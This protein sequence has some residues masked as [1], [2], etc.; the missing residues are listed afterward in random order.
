MN[1]SKPVF[2]IRP[3]KPV[4]PVEPIV[5]PPAPTAPTTDLQDMQAIAVAAFTAAKMPSQYTTFDLPNWLACLVAK[6][7]GGKPVL[8]MPVAVPTD[9]QNYNSQLSALTMLLMATGQAAGMPSVQGNSTAK[10]YT[11]KDLPSWITSLGL[12]S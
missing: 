7:A 8:P 5:S 9:I 11:M 10:N 3:A 4:K 12:K 1:K 6:K 2:G